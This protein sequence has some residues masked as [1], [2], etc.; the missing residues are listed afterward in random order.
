M[1]PQSISS[2]P[3]HCLTFDVEEHFQVNAFDSEARRRSWGSSESRVERST[4][5]LLALLERHRY[6]A[7]FFVLGWIAER[8]ASLVQRIA[9]AGHEIASHGYGH[10]I[11]TRLSPDEFRED[12]RKAKKILEDVIGAE[13]HGYRAP[14]FTIMPDTAWALEVLAQ[15]GHRW[16]S[17][18]VPIVHDVYGWPGANPFPHRIHT[19]SGP[20]FELPPST[21][22][23]LGA[24]RLPVGGGGYFRFYPYAVVRH[25]LR[26]IEAQGQPI[27]FYL[28]P[29]EVDPEQPRMQG[30]RLSVYRHYLNLERVEGRLERLLDDFRFAA[31]GDLLP[32]LERGWERAQRVQRSTPLR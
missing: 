18:V 7:T 26:R 9:A 5:K 24:T 13:I 15:E 23:G 12:V 30:K 17:S 1:L 32:A 21:A 20:L 16:D 14:S 27:V 29:W 19:P 8:H 31:V 4:E 2:P 22:N 6:R 10:E 25:F 3:L 11:I 28:H